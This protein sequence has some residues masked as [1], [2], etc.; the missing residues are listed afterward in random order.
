MFASYKGEGTGAVRHMF[1]HHILKPERVPLEANLWGTSKSSGSFSTLFAG[2]IRRAL[3]YAENPFEIRP[4]TFR[5]KGKKNEKVYG[6]SQKVGVSLAESYTSFSYGERVYISCGDSS[7]TDLPSGAVDAIITDPPFF[8]NVHYSQL[9]DFFYVWQRHILGTGIHCASL[10]TRSEREVQNADVATFTQRLIAI[11]SESCRVLK[12]NG[13]LAFTYH[14]SRSEGW[15]AVLEAL[16]ASDFGI[17]AAHPIKSEMS[18]AMPKHQAKEPINLDIIIVCRKRSQI[19]LHRELDDLWGAI[20]SAATDQVQRLHM[21]GR[22]LSR[23]DTRVIVMAQLV[24]QLS[25]FDSV[26][27]ALSSLEVAEGQAE[28]LIAKLHDASAISR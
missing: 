6:L 16:L 22:K 24:R 17:T 5:G 1:A 19:A 28:T 11:W 21:S 25:I 13:I 12:D 27:R 8:D 26:E 7:K 9:A 4:G 14:H 23:N 3:D 20:S 15:Y 18:V 2:R 10:T